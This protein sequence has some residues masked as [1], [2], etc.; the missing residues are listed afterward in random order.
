MMTEGEPLRKA[1]EAGRSPLTRLKTE[2]HGTLRS[3]AVLV[4][5]A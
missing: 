4:R 5:V 3:V 2:I 1:V